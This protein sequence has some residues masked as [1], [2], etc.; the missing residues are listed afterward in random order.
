MYDLNS[1]FFDDYFDNQ[2]FEFME[3]LYLTISAFFHDSL[4]CICPQQVLY[5]NVLIVTTDA[6]SYMKKAINALQLTYPKMI[7]MTCLAHALHRVAELVRSN[8]PN[9]NVLISSVK[10]VFVR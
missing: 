3:P 7:H 4:R 9:I 1:F 2:D 8:Y 5:N 10:N 6:A